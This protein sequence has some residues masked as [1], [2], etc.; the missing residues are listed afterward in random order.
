MDK[1][2]KKVIN[3]PDK[4]VKL[5]KKT[6]FLRNKARQKRGGGYNRGIKENKVNICFSCCPTDERRRKI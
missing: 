5:Y 4:D 3:P 2:K 1:R 6:L